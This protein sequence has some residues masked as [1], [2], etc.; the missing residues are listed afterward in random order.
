VDDTGNV[1]VAD[2]VNDTIRKITP[3]AVVTTLAGLPLTTGSADG[4]GSNA[5]FASPQGLGV[6][7]TMHLFVSDTGNNTIRIGGSVSRPLNIST[8]AR[9]ETGQNVMIGGFII[10]GD[11]AK[12][13]IIRA[14]G[15]SLEQ[16]G[17]TDILADP[18]LELHGSDG[19]LITEDDNWKDD[20]DQMALITATGLA[21]SDDLE[22][23]IV[24]TLDP[25]SYTAIVN[26]G[27]GG[28]GI[29]LV[30]VYDLGEETGSYLANISTRGFVQT[31]DNVMIGGF[32]LGGGTSGAQV[33]VRAIGPSLGAAG[34]NGALSDPTL[35]LRDADGTLISSNDN[36]QD[37]EQTEN[38]QDYPGGCR[39]DPCRSA[40][41]RGKR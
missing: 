10:G 4:A 39:H 41:D 34:V 27:D 15:P 20:P 21:P 38:S 26:G 18:N 36:W 6:D 35:E 12:T 7:S 25:G 19:S 24:A 5:R 13:V 1:Y 37:S 33:L 14:I 11:E 9:V 22:S 17:L 30:E 32:I 40:A 8:R 23:A 29:G 3:A 2:T 31:G 16:V 28:T